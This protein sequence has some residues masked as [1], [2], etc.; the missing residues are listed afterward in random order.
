M[1]SEPR[2][3]PAPEPAA[4]SGAGRTD[5]SGAN[6]SPRANGSGGAKAPAVLVPSGAE[7]ALA[8]VERH[9][10]QEAIEARLVATSQ[11]RATT[12]VARPVG[13]TRVRVAPAPVDD[14]W[15]DGDAEFWG[16]TRP[17]RRPS[18]DLDELPADERRSV[19]RLQARKVRRILRHVSPWSVFKFSLLFYL[20][21]WLIALIAGVILWRV[22]QEAGAISNIET[23]YA[24][25]T[26][27]VTFELDGR[28]VFRAAASAGV[29]L[30]T[31][32]TALTV[33]LAVL[34]NL[35]TDLTGGVRMTV[36][37]LGDARRPVNTRR[38]GGRSL[39]RRVRP[40]AA[41]AKGATGKVASGS[42]TTTAL[43][44]ADE[45]GSSRRVP[46]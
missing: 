31:A 46:A 38:A 44:S 33:M 23:F 41:A 11:P 7:S 22:G 40:G 17:R 43:G 27:E 34:F 19:G 15:N 37:E 3:T 25:A 6:G 4:G 2:S 14:G 10:R 42:S 18:V 20:C 13:G 36:V 26:G 8:A 28:A 12:S 39:L 9:L 16:E 35:I 45:G 21:V 5:G 30:V 1:P 32:G 29:V 24:K